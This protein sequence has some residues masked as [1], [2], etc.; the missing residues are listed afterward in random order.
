MYIFGNF[1]NHYHQNYHHD[2]HCKHH[3]SAIFKEK[4]DYVGIFPLGCI[5]HRLNT[6]DTNRQKNGHKQT[7]ER[8]ETDRRI[9]GEVSDSTVM[10]WGSPQLEVPV[11][12]D[13]I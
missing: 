4:R 8:T 13:R 5:V 12:L 7:E 9:L 10:Q 3:S 2:Y 6:S 11:L 1:C